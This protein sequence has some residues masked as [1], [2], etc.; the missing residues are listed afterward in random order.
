MVN[1]N[2]L[3]LYRN[4]VVREKVKLESYFPLYTIH[5]LS[6]HYLY[7]TISNLI[8]LELVTYGHIAS[9]ILLYFQLSKMSFHPIRAIPNWYIEVVISTLAMNKPTISLLSSRLTYGTS[10]SSSNY[11]QQMPSWTLHMLR[12]LFTYLFIKASLV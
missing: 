1:V 4:T 3:L 11:S 6:I 12:Q 5:I 10:R 7:P 2:W 9:A 8:H